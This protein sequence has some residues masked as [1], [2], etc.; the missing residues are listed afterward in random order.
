MNKPLKKAKCKTV[1]ELCSLTWNAPAGENVWES[2]DGTTVIWRCCGTDWW[3]L[4]EHPEVGRS[5]ARLS[6]VSRVT[7]CVL[8]GYC[9]GFAVPWKK[10]KTR[11]LANALSPAG[12]TTEDVPADSEANEPLKVG[13]YG[14]EFEVEELKSPPRC[15]PGP[16]PRPCRASGPG[17]VRPKCRPARRMLWK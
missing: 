17:R 9:E 3:I 16:A 1:Q 10:F 5:L 11:S 6:N 4:T 14:T 8:G 12:D 2:P 13:L 15:S 7:Q